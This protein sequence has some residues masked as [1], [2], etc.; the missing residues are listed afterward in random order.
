MTKSSMLTY[1]RK[2]VNKIA[3]RKNLNFLNSFSIAT[4]LSLIRCYE[5]RDLPLLM[6]VKPNKKL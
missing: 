5:M 6:Q 2:T 3:T 1:I 4:N